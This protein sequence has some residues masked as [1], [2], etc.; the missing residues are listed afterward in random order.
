M[1]K[2]TILLLCILLLCGCTAPA[3]YDGP[4]QSAWVLSEQ[5][6]TYHADGSGQEEGSRTTYTYDTFG[7]RTRSLTYQDGEL[8]SERDYAYDDRGNVTSLV[9]W[10]HSGL[11]SWPSSRTGYTYDGQNRPTATIYRNFLG[12][13]RRRD[14]YTYDDTEHTVLWEG[15][16]DTQT[17]WLDGDGKILRALTYSEPADIWM[18][19]RYEY[20]GEGRSTGIT[21]YY[22][23]ALSS[24]AALVYDDQGRIVEE[25]YLDSSGAVYSR[26]TR[27]YGENT[28]TTYD[29]DGNKTVETYRPDGQIEKMEQFNRQGELTIV[30]RYTYTEIRVPALREE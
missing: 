1:K 11:L 21:S 9:V 7:N 2:R 16:Y 10:D 25:T 30:T 24:T 15:R 26:R 28:V 12:L 14:T 8:S 17:T 6:T 3:V 20:D 23:E 29:L 22:D 13:E 18:E 19:T 5:V 27:H 4:T